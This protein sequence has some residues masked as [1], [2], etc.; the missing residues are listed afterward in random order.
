VKLEF[1]NAQGKVVRTYR[2]TDPVRKPD[3]ATDPVAYNKFCQEMPGA[4]DCGLPLYW[5]APPQVLK[6]STG[7][8][9]FTWDMHYDVVPGTSGRGRGDGATGAVP[10]RTYP[11]MNSPWVAPGAYTVRL[12]ADGRSAT[13]SILIKMDPRVKVTAAVQEIF[14]L[15]T[16]IENVAQNALT[17]Q[18]EA[19][20]LLDKLKTRP[21]AADTDA[22]IK[23]LEEIAPA[24]SPATAV[25]PTLTSIGGQLI[26][27]V[28]SMQAAEMP[29]TAAELA[30]CAKQEAAY[31]V[32]MA[33][34]S[35]LKAA[36]SK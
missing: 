17:A 12:T 7:M 3:P 23:K 15:T 25:A 26:G 8:H 9:R 24:E 20:T 35:A 34:W 22:L 36:A 2:S 31:G 19:R 4:P 1:L 27:S 6:M 32:L 5:P 21:A 33:K 18:L 28:M 11:A 14:T 13:Q 30:A 10:H 16:R 29:P